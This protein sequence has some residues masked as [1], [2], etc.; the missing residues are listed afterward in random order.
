MCV[1]LYN[2][3]YSWWA[4]RL[5]SF[6]LF[7]FVWAVITD[8]A[9]KKQL[10]TPLSASLVI[11]WGQLAK[12]RRVLAVE[13][14]H[15]TITARA[16]RALIFHVADFIG[17]KVLC[18]PWNSLQLQQFLF[19]FPEPS[20]IAPSAQWDDTERKKI[21]SHRTAH[22]TSGDSCHLLRLLLSNKRKCLKLWLF[23][24]KIQVCNKWP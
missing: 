6:L 2:R 23:F 17:R 19:C 20:T 14:V 5:F 7:Y 18:G 4:V 11:S 22:E 12:W 16:S 9:I 10:R 1:G 3:L 8:D 15:S 24:R 13:S 21:C